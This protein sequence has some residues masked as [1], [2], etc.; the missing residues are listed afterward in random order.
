MDVLTLAAL[1]NRA[2]GITGD[3]EGARALADLLERP[4]DS[5]PDLADLPANA[6]RRF[7]L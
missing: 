4:V 3:D 6:L 5:T 2:R 7:G 1:M